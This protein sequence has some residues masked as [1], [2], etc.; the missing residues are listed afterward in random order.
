[1]RDVVFTGNSVKVPSTKHFQMKCL[2]RNGA[3]T[4]S[5]SPVSVP[6]LVMCWL[7]LGFS[8]PWLGEIMSRALPTGFGLAR[9]FLNENGKFFSNGIL[10]LKCFQTVPSCQFIF[11][12]ISISIIINNLCGYRLR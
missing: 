1:M 10:H 5:D 2:H 11:H 9:G 4:V 8:W 12:P 3:L 6:L 7:W